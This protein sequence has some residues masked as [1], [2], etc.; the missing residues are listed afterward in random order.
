MRYEPTINYGQI[1]GSMH[2]AKTKW[3]YN[4]PSTNRYLMVW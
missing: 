4:Q 2:I 1:I 3:I